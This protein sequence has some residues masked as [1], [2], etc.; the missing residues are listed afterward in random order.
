MHMSHTLEGSGSTGESMKQLVP[1][2]GEMMNVSL[3]YRTVGNCLD[4]FPFAS[5]HSHA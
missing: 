3:N 4:V 5:M 1:E 2:E